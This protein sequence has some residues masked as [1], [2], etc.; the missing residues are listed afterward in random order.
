MRNDALNSVPDS[1][2]MVDRSSCS[3][4]AES[5]AVNNNDT[6]KQ[7]SPPPTLAPTHLQP[8]T[9]THK[10]QAAYL[11]Q[12]G[13]DT[14]LRDANGDSAMHWAAYKGELAIVQLLHHLGL[15]VR[16]R[17]W[18]CV[19]CVVKCKMSRAR[20]CVFVLCCV[21][22]CVCVYWGGGKGLRPRR[23]T[24]WRGLDLSFPPTSNSS[25]LPP[26]HN[27]TLQTLHT[28]T[29][30]TARRRGRLRAG[31]PAL[32][33]APGQF[34][35]GRILGPGRRRADGAQGDCAWI[36]LIVIGTLGLALGL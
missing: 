28:N 30:K 3:I 25:T 1:R 11:I 6:P 10:T 5:F 4:V 23:E 22:V 7:S 36:G 27:K 33:G 17:L 13:A 14:G 24:R 34:A 35:R 8:P 32:G 9:I 20:V 15:P 18:I 12:G 2:T 21:C 31:A 19:L 29:H 16:L 26:P